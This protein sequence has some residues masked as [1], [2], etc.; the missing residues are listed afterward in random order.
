MLLLLA[1]GCTPENEFFARPF[2]SI[3]V[4]SGDFDN[5]EQSLDRLEVAY[6]L[7]EGYI[8]CASYDSDIDPSLI[9]LKSETL[10][11]GTTET[12]TELGIHDALFVNS[13]TRGFGRWKYNGIEEDDS[14][15]SDPAVI[16]N[17]VDFV[18][19]GRTLVV[20]DW[21]YDLVEAGWPDKIDFY[22]EDLELDAAQAG[23]PGR[24]T[25]RVTDDSLGVE[26][27]SDTAGLE[28]NYTNWAVMESVG[29][30][31]TVYL[32]GDIEYRISE[33][34]GYGTLEDVPLLVGWEV[35]NGEVIFS[36]FHWNSQS[37]GV[38]DA[39]LTTLVERLDPGSADD[40]VQPAEDTGAA[41]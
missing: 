24:I 37:A 30:G 27:D 32:R 40:S 39:I 17:V 14:L 38:T 10:F 13:G 6:Q 5:M 8:C 12:G 36:S 28:F 21:A 23:N 31:V 3:A 16:A 18:G 11:T 22:G 29:E 15:V 1:A 20:S 2:E 26:L 34:E 33:T 35:G 9:N 41:E 4:V 25:A 19:R 7:Y